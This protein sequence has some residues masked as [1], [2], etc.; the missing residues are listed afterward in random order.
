[1][2]FLYLGSHFSIWWTKE[3]AF[4]LNISIKYG[5]IKRRNKL[6][7]FRASVNKVALSQYLCIYGGSCRSHPCKYFRHFDSWETLYIPHPMNIHGPL[8]RCL[9][10]ETQILFLPFAPF[11][12]PVNSFCL[13]PATENILF[14]YFHVQKTINDELD[15][16]Q[17]SK[18]TKYSYRECPFLKGI[19]LP[20]TKFINFPLL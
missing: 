2:S 1:M 6:T 8:H 9:F 19:L 7:K 4:S 12:I 11:H 15:S 16:W 18:L 3:K 5:E 10:S 20:A 13:S 14:Q 17:Q